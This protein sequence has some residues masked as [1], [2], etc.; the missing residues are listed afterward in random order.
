V[1]DPSIL[2]QLFEAN[3]DSSEDRSEV[4]ARYSQ[5]TF[6]IGNPSGY[7]FLNGARER[8]LEKLHDPSDR[9]Q[10][11]LRGWLAGDH[12]EWSGWA[13]LLHLGDE[14]AQSVIRELAGKVLAHVIEE[15]AGVEEADA[16]DEAVQLLDVLAPALVDV[17]EE[18]VEKLFKPAA[19]IS[20]AAEWWTDDIS[21]ACQ[22][23]RHRLL[24]RVEELAPRSAGALCGQRSR[25]AVRPIGG[26][27]EPGILIVRGW[28]E[29]AEALEDETYEELFGALPKSDMEA[30]PQL[31]AETLATEIVLRRCGA[32]A[33]G[34]AVVQGYLNKL[35]TVQNL[36]SEYRSQRE[37]AAEA[38]IELGPVSTQLV[39]LL[40]HIGWDPPA[41]A[42]GM[43]REWSRAAGPGPTATLIRDTMRLYIADD[44]MPV[45]KECKY[46]EAPVLRRT[47]K[48]LLKD[49]NEIR[50]R[51][52]FAN[53]L[54]LLGL[55][56]KGGP[57]K[58]AA[59]II[60]LLKPRRAKHRRN[61]LPVALFLCE[62]VGAKHNKAPAIEKVLIAY[63][64]KWDCQYTPDQYRAILAAG[65]NLP[66]QYLSE[67]T[68]KGLGKIV[69]EFG[70]SVGKMISSI[71][72]LSR[73]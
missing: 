14:A 30:A 16:I 39:W 8:I 6:E 20:L 31:Y 61:D 45:F 51:K 15:S 13:E 3:L 33:G 27:L 41:H 23:G 52:R 1:G 72:P 57:D 69:E 56:T 49:K 24:R 62:C 44:W 2:S 25:D 17:G 73:K 7:R 66:E 67:K 63:S 9:A 55:R 18:E 19:E 21:L 47:E 11:I 53:S 54:R 59:M 71:N 43:V 26:E 58:V 28:R 50:E 10:F 22:A 68:R 37:L 40:W 32:F 35:D 29:F 70:G 38:C 12:S 65:V 48:V 60:Q 5:R 34:R 42:K 4:L 46:D 36:G 64:K